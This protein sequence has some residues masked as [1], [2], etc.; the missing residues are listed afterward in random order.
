MKFQQANRTLDSSGG[1]TVRLQDL[2]H[3]ALTMMNTTCVGPST[4][5]RR[6]AM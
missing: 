4:K 1:P 3:L 6:T 5:H 2:Q